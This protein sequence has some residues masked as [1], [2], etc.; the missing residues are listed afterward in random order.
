MGALNLIALG[1]MVGLALRSEFAAQLAATG[2]AEAGKLAE[3]V[4]S[5]AKRAG[6]KLEA[7]RKA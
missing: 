1:I 2:K 4:V 3:P 7:A 6:V 5:R